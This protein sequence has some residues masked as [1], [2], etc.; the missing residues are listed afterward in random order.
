MG[1]V[2]RRQFLTACGALIATPL[3]SFAQERSK[4]RSVGCLSLWS[5]SPWFQE[6]L[7]AALQTVGYEEGRNLVIEWR[8]ADGK[9]ENLAALAVNLVNRRVDV[10][11]A[12]L[13]D[14]ILAAKQATRAIPIVMVFASAPVEM[15]IVASLRRPAGN[16]TGTTWYSPETAQKMLQILNEA[17]PSANR[18]AV[19]RNP[20]YPGMRLYARDFDRAAH[21][22]GMQ[23]EYF[24]ATRG[25]AVPAILDRIAASRA[26]GFVFAEDPVLRP[27]GAAVA[28]FVRDRKW[29]SIGSSGAWG[30]AGGLFSFAPSIGETLRRTASF[31]DRILRGA[32]PAEL[33]VEMPTQYE[34]AINLKTAKAIGLKIPQSVL[35]RADRVI[36]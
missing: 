11:V 21:A 31:V 30:Q 23:L 5:T 19:L 24:D 6:Q 14:E 32:N 29:V 1:Q 16:V 35:M 12:P 26:N 18:I 8:W 2:Q 4:V 7:S 22:L 15:G 17:Q 34:F 20:E 10:I 28:K 36:E 9:P 33:P 27:H 3:A 13:D 25:E